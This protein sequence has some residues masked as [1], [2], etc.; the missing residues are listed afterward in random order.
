[1]IKEIPRKNL[2]THKMC[3][4]GAGEILQGSVFAN[5]M[6][7]FM[8]FTSWANNQVFFSTMR[9]A[10]NALVREV[11]QYQMLNCLTDNQCWFS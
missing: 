1:M 10:Y 3:I 2:Y 7:F 11:I 9:L 5:E 6:T 4:P 8:S